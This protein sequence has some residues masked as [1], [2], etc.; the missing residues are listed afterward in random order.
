MLVSF[1]FAAD[2]PTGGGEEL[3]ESQCAKCHGVKGVGTESGPPMVH[4]IY[5]PGHHSDWSFRKAMS[6]GV[7]AHHWR[8]GD[9]ERVTGL[10]EEQGE[11]IIKYIR[12]IQREAGIF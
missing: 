2:G 10:T 5:E 9:M 3:F 4:K 1:A 12:S 11:Q 7:R 6:M 8:F